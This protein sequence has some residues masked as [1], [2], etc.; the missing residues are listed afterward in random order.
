MKI[1]R[2]QVQTVA[3]AL[4]WVSQQE[5]SNNYIHNL[6]TACGLEYV[7][8]R[9]LGILISLFPTYNRELEYQAEKAERE[10]Q[11]AAERASEANSQAH[12]KHW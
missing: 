11:W 9:N 4:S 10:R 1:L 6:K 3:D 12:W 8:G 5:E 2:I 7:T